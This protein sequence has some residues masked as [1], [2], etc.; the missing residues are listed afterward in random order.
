MKSE[1][2]DAVLKMLQEIRDKQ[3]ETIAKQDKMD[4]HLKQIHKDCRRDSIIAGGAAGVVTGGVVSVG[5][6]YIRAKLGL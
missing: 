4:E 5:V 6:A 2:Q 1:Q 3:D